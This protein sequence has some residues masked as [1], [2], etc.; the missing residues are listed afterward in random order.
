MA[1]E[2][3]FKSLR[4]ASGLSQVKL[5]ELSGISSSEISRIESGTLQKPSDFALKALAP[6]MGVTYTE[7]INNAYNLKG[8]SKKISGDAEIINK[9]REIY[10]T[11]REWFNIAYDVALLFRKG[12]LEDLKKKL[13][14][15]IKGLKD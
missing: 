3:Y 10:L 9:A 6:H 4:K 5:A 14:L 11:D 15:T 1:F 7:L 12:E 2:R 8:K 13:A